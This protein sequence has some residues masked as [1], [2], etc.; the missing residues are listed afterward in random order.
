M[1]KLHR[2]AILVLLISL[3]IAAQETV[4]SKRQSPGTIRGRIFFGEKMGNQALGP[5]SDIKVVATTPS[6]QS[7]VQ[8]ASGP[9]SGA[10]DGQCTFTLKNI[11]PNTPIQL[12]AV[13][14]DFSSYPEKTYPPP[15]GQWTNPLTV[16]PLETVTKFIEIDGKP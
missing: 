12:K 7:V 16:K 9:S 6:G 2:Y 4:T 10:K 11:Y 8:T 15:N 14:S 5:C 13:Y 3:V 1:K